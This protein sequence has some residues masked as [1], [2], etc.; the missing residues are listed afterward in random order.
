MPPRVLGYRA[1]VALILGLDLGTQSTK[2]LVCE[3]GPGLPVRGRGRSNHQPRFPRPGWAEHDP[4]AWEQ[5]LAPAIAMALAAA[6]CGPGDIGALAVAGQLDGMVAID[7]GG[8]PLGPCLI[9]LDRRATDCLPALDPARFTAVTGQIADAG[10]LAAKARWWDRHGGARAAAFHQPVSYLVERL[11]GARVIDP[12]L[13]SMSMVYDLDRGDWSDELLAAFELDRG[14]LPRLAPADSIAGALTA[15]G[16]ALTGLPIGTPVAVGT[17]DDF[18]SA[19]GAGLP[20]ETLLDVVGTAEVVA[21]RSATALGDRERLVETHA[22]PTGGFVVGN[23]GWLAG[24]ALRWFGALTGR[25]IETLDQA[26]SQAPVGA[27][28]VSFLPALGGAMTP[29]WDPTARGAFVGLAPGHEVGE[30][31]RAMYEACAFAMVDVA[32]R[33]AQLGLPTRAI[34]LLGG[35]ARSPTWAQIK[36]DALDR[37]VELA[38]ELDGSPL[39]AAMLA[40]VA[41]GYAPSLTV[42]TG[43]APP[44]TRVFTPIAGHREAMLTGHARYRRLYAALRT[45]G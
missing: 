30:L 44:P 9:W 23:P 3:P 6:G 10:H 17:G 41:A 11:T 24:G 29:V 19:L 8:H 39:G 14:R 43:W 5:G 13:A 38:G 27:G 36:A 35:G 45:V 25:A 22:Y 2:A 18:A 16:A 15:R 26:A 33:L 1:A 40:A 21:I 4:A 7:A 37:P 12:A 32:D 34:R 31:V 20:P 42:A 28:G